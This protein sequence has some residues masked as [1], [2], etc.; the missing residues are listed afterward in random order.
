MD[1]AQLQNATLAHLKKYIVDEFILEA[2]CPLKLGKHTFQ[3]T[4][5]ASLGALDALSNEIKDHMLS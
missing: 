1:F 5:D 3:S 2:R 4:P